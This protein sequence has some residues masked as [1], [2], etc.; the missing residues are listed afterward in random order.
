M[1]PKYLEFFKERHTLDWAYWRALWE[2]FGRMLLPFGG[3]RFQF[4]LKNIFK[5]YNLFWFQ[6][7]LIAENFPAIRHLEFRF[8]EV[9]N[10]DSNTMQTY[11]E[12]GARLRSLTF[13]ETVCCFLFWIMFNSNTNVISNL[14]I[15]L[16]LCIL[17]LNYFNIYFIFYYNFF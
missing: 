1:K 14:P 10:L 9:N 8:C 13:F 5:N 16:N 6:I 4:G 12:F 3:H 15:L 2:S 7:R 11:R 17:I